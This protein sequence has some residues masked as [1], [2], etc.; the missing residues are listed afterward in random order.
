MVALGNKVGLIMKISDKTYLLKKYQ[1]IIKKPRIDNNVKNI[2]R[3]IEEEINYSIP[4]SVQKLIEYGEEINAQLNDVFGGYEVYTAE[5][6]QNIYL[7]KKAKLSFFSEYFI[8][9]SFNMIDDQSIELAADSTNYEKVTNLSRFFPLCH[10]K[11]D[12]IVID[13][14]SD[15]SLTEIM[16][17][18][19][20]EVVSPNLDIHFQDLID[21]LES[22]VYKIDSDGDISYPFFWE[23]RK[24]LKSGLVEMDEYGE[25]IDPNEEDVT[26]NNVK[27][28]WF[29][30][31]W[32]SKW[33]K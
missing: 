30:K 21:G 5:E 15:A 25:I 26:S 33:D 8:D 7:H 10:H 2:I 6:I 3:V 16:L 28:P 29:V 14:E 20:A 19:S 24:K 22:K 9:Q 18:F 23:M 4:K 32:L 17:G 1:K 31:W 13:L 27:P 12:Y 11:G